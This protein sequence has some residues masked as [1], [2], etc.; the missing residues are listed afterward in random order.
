MD[1]ELT[2]KVAVVTGASRGVGKAIARELAKEGVDVALCARHREALE[3]AASELEQETGRRILP[4]PTDTTNWES[5]R[6][7]VETTAVTLGRVDILVN[8]AATPGGLVRGTLADA[9]EQDLLEDINTLT[10]PILSFSEYGCGFP[11]S[12][13]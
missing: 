3:E 7:M 6:R 2:G 9:N 5:V 12:T 4:V 13:P 10:F 1:L 8:N 11:D